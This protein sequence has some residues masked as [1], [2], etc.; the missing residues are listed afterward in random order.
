MGSG[1]ERFRF[2][3][4]SSVKAV[5]LSSGNGHYNLASLVRMQC[6]NQ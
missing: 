6:V 4:C 3:Y 5:S 1:L 2:I